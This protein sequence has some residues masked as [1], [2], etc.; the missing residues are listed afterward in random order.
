MNQGDRIYGF[1]VIR[2]QTLSEADSVLIEMQHDKTKAKLIWMK[3]DEDNKLFSIAFKTIPCDDTGVFHILEHSVLGG[4]RRYPVKEPFLELMKSSMST[5]LNAMTFPD[6]TVFPVSSRND[7][8][9]INLTKVYLDAVFCPSIYD[10]PCIFE[11]EGWH[12]ELKSKEDIPSYKGVVFNEMKG[13][14][15]SVY[16]RIGTEMNRLLFPETCYRFES[17]GE[18]SAIPKLTYEQFL[19]THHRFYHPSNAYIYLDGSVNIE[20][21]LKLLDEEYLSHYEYCE[22][23]LDIPY[24]E[25]ITSAEKCIDYEIT[26]EESKDNLTHIIWGK[27]LGDFKDCKKML[28]ASVIGEALA[29]SN[30]A[31][32]K[33]ELLN[34]GLCFDVSLGLYDGI[35]QPYG[36][37]QIQNTDYEKRNEVKE[38]VNSIISALVEKGIDREM[39]KAAIDRMEFRYREGSE[40]KGLERN[41]NVLYSWMHGGDPE[42]YLCRD[43][44]FA[45]LR[46]QL[47]TDYYEKLLAEW[48]LDENGRAYLYCLPSYT[49]GEELRKNEKEYLKLLSKNWTSE[50]IENILKSNRQLD[51]WQ[52]SEDT[53]EAL[54]SLPKLSLDEVG[55]IPQLIETAVSEQYGMTVLSHSSKEKKVVSV[56]LYFLLSD[57]TEQEISLLSAMT[58]LLGNLPT[59]SMNGMELQQRIK[60]LL[61]DLQFSINVFSKNGNFS[62]CR[63]YFVVKTRFLRENINKALCLLTEILKET[64]FS[65]LSLIRE[66]LLQYYEELKYSIVENG[67][68]FAIKRVRASLSAESSVRELTAGYESY[69]CLHTLLEQLDNKIELFRKSAEK[70]FC[71]S[72]LTVS[73]TSAKEVSL[74]VLGSNLPIGEKSLKEELNY[75]LNIP[76]A[77]GIT[78]PTSV[79]YSSAVLPEIVSD[80]PLWQVAASILSLE[81]L[82]NEIRVKGGAYG[83]GASVSTS[84][85]VIFYSFRDPHANDSLTTYHKASD[86]LYHY[87]LKN[88][89]MD[90]YIISTIAK[91]EPLLTDS[92]KG[93]QA[94]ENY[95]RGITNEELIN[96][97]KR[98]LSLTCHDLLALC[99]VLEKHG[100]C[101]VIGSEND[102]KVCKSHNLKIENIG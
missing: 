1:T 56:N 54:S 29:G 23:N 100:V 82:W 26:Y 27:V 13:Y 32:L 5:F 10:N 72:R 39:L 22:L 96:R 63:P 49:Y 2:V 4:S 50:D 73:V 70:I 89:E 101:C 62:S 81:Y 8:D 79:S 53:I 9:F 57:C 31:T 64:D 35:L 46:K 99:K 30:D 37:M 69:R 6:K 86:F 12:I 55:N 18:P 45:F 15:S 38:T 94:D 19:N 7:A 21:V 20:A 95:F 75:R 24:Q 14:M 84:G 98:M 91:L 88:T 33:R 77:Q 68:Q 102:L 65:D 40:P 78:V 34:K 11:Q 67:H 59:T 44:V 58:W 92:E 97:R 74:S 51:D 17:G 42:M 76:Q 87:C 90:S 66:L 61:G 48:L 52:K 36:F 25:Q 43:K 80:I 71:I 93:I 3:S 83:T 85:E 60:S 28:A 41:L 47:K 16:N